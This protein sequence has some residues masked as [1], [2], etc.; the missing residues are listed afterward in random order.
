MTLADVVTR[1][2]VL[3]QAAAGMVARRAHAG[4]RG[5]LS[6]E[7]IALAAAA[8]IILGTVSSQFGDDIGR[9]IANAVQNIAGQATE[10]SG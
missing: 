1:L 5:G 4:Q 8:V 10:M 6:V 7:W 9:G 3:A 2:T